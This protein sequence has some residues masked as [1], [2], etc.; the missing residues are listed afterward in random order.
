MKITKYDYPFN[1]FR[2][3]RLFD[4]DVFGIFPAVKR[5][6]EPPMDIYQNEKEFVVELQVPKAI[7]EKVGVS[8]EDGVLKIEGY[9]E[10]KREED[11]RHYFRRE[12]R[13]GGFAKMISLPVPVK[14]D[15]SKAVFSDGVL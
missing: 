4:D 1:P 9:Q 3:E 2:I 10:D 5:H 11:G 13:R 6:F 14:E 15:E 12:I 8:V 7:A